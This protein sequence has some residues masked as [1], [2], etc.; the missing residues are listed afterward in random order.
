MKNNHYSGLEV[1]VIGISLRTSQATDWRKFW[2]NL[3][4]AKECVRFLGKEELLEQGVP[5]S[6]INHPDFVN[7]ATD[8]EDKEFFDAPFFGYSNDEAAFMNPDHRYFHECVWEAIE[9]AGYNLDDCKD[10]IGVYAGASDDV[11]WKTYVKVANQ[12]GMVNDFYLDKITNKDYLSSLI[13]YKLNLTGPSLTLNT[14]CSTSLVAIHMACKALIFGETKMALAG[15]SSLS[16]VLQKGYLYEEGAIL[17]KDGHCRSFDINST[18]TIGGEGGGVVVLKRLK[19]A[20]EDGDHIYG[21]IKGSA[22]NNDGNRKIGYTA[23]SVAGQVACIKMAQKFSR[24][25]ASTIGY[26]ETHG[27]GTKL[28]DSIEVEA[29]NSAFNYN[30]DQSC[31]IGSVK[32]NIGHLDT[33]AGVAGLVKTVLSLY[34]N[35]IPASLHFEKPDPAINFSGGPFYVNNTLKAWEH[36]GEHPKRAAINSF[37]VGGTNAHLILE[38]APERNASEQENTHNLVVVSAKTETS[39]VNYLDKLR[40][41]LE[42]NPQTNLSDLSYTLQTGRK[43]FDYRMAFSVATVNELIENLTDAVSTGKKPVHLT[44]DK[45]TI[46]FA[47]PGQGSQFV[48]MGK[49]L[50]HAVPE[51]RAIMDNGFAILNKITGQQFKEKLFNDAD[52]ESINETAI[53]QPLLFLSQYALASTLRGFGIE[54]NYMIGHSIGEYAAACLSGVFSFEDT[55]KIVVKRGELMNALPK[56]S[57]LSVPV[58][59]VSAQKYLTDELS[60]AA[61]NGPEQLVFSGNDAAIEKLMEQLSEDEIPFVKLHTSHAFHSSMQ[62]GILEPFEQVFKVIEINAPQIPFISNLSGELI[63]DEESKSPAYW[64]KQLRSTVNFSKGIARVLAEK[65]P[66]ILEVGAGHSL[67][68]LTKQQEKGKTVLAV[69]LMRSVKQTDNDEQFFYQK[70]GELWSNGIEINWNQLHNERK[71][72]KISLPTYAFDRHKF[73]VEVDIMKMVGEVRPSL[74]QDFKNSFYLPSWKKSE[75]IETTDDASLNVLFFTSGT[76]I[77]ETISTQLVQHQQQLVEVRM[78]DAFIKHA[79]DKYTVNPSEPNHFDLLFEALATDDI[80][81]DRIVYGWA[82]EQT[83]SNLELNATNLPYNL[84]YFSL[85]E[86]VNKCPAHDNTKWIILTNSLQSVM[87]NETIRHNQSLLLGLLYV[88]QQEKQLDTLNIDVCGDDS[89]IAE[90]CVIEMLQNDMRTE[91]VVAF[92]SGRRW[93]RD[94]QKIPFETKKRQALKEKGVYLITGGLGRLGEV[95]AEYL[96]TTY[97]AQVILLGRTDLAQFGEQTRERWNKLIGLQPET[98]YFKIDITD[99]AELEK[100][101]SQH[102]ELFERL[103]GIIHLAGNVSENDIEFLDHTTLEKTTAML[104]PKVTGT[105]NLHACFENTNLDFFWMSSSLAASLGGL[106][107]GAYAAANAYLD[108][109]ALRH[110]SK[111]YKCVEFPAIHFDE[112]P[113]NGF[114]NVLD[115]REVIAVLEKTLNVKNSPV[116]HIS[117]EDLMTLHQPKEM[118][119]FDENA[120]SAKKT[121][122]P[123]LSVEFCEASTETEQHLTTLFEGFFGIEGIGI[124][125]DFF[126]LGGDSLKAMVLVKKINQELSLSISISDFL[127]NNTIEKL[128]LLVDEKSWLNAEAEFQNEMII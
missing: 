75:L 9:D 24:V 120:S 97:D 125:D 58:D 64:S 46:V 54:P 122:R 16:N 49:D 123:H 39:V 88:I 23:P 42:N 22:V 105:E 104:L 14:A 30:K 45:K 113:I 76:P 84:L 40:G 110:A 21:V 11:I 83:G 63:R 71:R 67:I 4:D 53:A 86:L 59:E 27:T 79:S 57:M 31:P 77:S 62:D 90:Q 92:R 114:Q 69:N 99:K 12:S 72:N 98:T 19:D 108:Y 2:N 121:E 100:C 116:F 43:K 93:V 13:S 10:S 55:L 95:V 6:L 119:N 47:F 96:I 73:T 70:L 66:V 38:E 60:I 25:E 109:F 28:G 33:A 124:K 65:N 87:G 112:T 17:S 51:Y 111:G 1:A 85:V 126:E 117:K 29:L 37:G 115:K 91:R 50:Y 26:I 61:I 52:K 68:S 32:S 127:M 89:E 41:F 107:F 82:T 36:T 78:G 5:E 101:I 18:G 74:I 56:G 106:R 15:A 44:N 20:I 8:L 34:N 3:K 48:N 118:E 80:S 7:I 103:N 94:F 35:Q 128:A 81:I 102:S